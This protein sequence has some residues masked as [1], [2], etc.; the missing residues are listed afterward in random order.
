[1]QQIFSFVNGKKFQ[2]ER[3]HKLCN[4]DKKLFICKWRSKFKRSVNIFWPDPEWDIFS[5]S[6]DIWD[7][8]LSR[9][10]WRIPI[11]SYSNFLLYVSSMLRLWCPNLKSFPKKKKKM[12]DIAQEIFCLRPLFAFRI[13]CWCCLRAWCVTCFSPMME[14][15]T[16]GCLLCADDTRLH[17]WT[18][19]CN[20]W[21]LFWQG[22]PSL[23]SARSCHEFTQFWDFRFEL[24]KFVTR[25]KLTWKDF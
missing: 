23:S 13:V 8:R 24:G 1:M 20:S 19:I 9:N 4:L 3:I 2:L 15:I 25:G 21:E 7:C 12:T 10:N 6:K 22:T 11:V 18:N 5:G 16:D 14:T 17:G